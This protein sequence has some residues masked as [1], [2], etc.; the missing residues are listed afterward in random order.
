MRSILR[1]ISMGG[2]ALAL[3]VGATGCDTAPRVRGYSEAYLA[4]AQAITREVPGDYFV[5]RRYYNPYFKFWG[6]VRQ[7]GQSWKTARLVMLNENQKLAPDREANNFGVDD[8]A[9]YHLHG[10][11]TG[12]KV[13]EPTSNRLYPEFLLAG[14]ELVNRSPA[15]IFP[16]GGR[17]PDTVIKQPY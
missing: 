10:R 8:N 9:E 6:Y 2:T 14:Y 4:Q 12:E 11:F 1:V 3:S 17:L 15:S 13:Y 16:P 7:P 5:G